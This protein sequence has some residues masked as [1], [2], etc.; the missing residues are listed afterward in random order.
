MRTLTELFAYNAWAN[1]QVFATC[2]TVDQARLDAE[3]PGTFG[4][5][6]ETLKHQVQ[7]EA[8]YADMLR[9]KPLGTQY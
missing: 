1:A 2:G 7:V 6:A 5:L 9:D 3:A 8:V 4:T